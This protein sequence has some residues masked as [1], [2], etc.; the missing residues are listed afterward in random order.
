MKNLEVFKLIIH[1]I[2]QI[3]TRVIQKLTVAHFIGTCQCFTPNH[4]NLILPLAFY[5][6]KIR[7]DIIL[8]V[9]LFS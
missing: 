3:H 2:Y 5:I 1:I 9:C 6:F 4:S 7:F 8:S